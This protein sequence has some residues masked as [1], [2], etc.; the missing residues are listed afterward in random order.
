MWA[1]GHF[2][3]GKECSICG[4]FEADKPDFVTITTSTMPDDGGYVEVFPKQIVMSKEEIYNHL[5]YYFNN[6]E[7]F[8]RFADPYSHVTDNDG[9]KNLSSGYPWVATDDISEILDL[10]REEGFIDFKG[11]PRS[12]KGYTVLKLIP[13]SKYFEN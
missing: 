13:R 3:E 12:K 7:K 6:Q 4:H 1:P 8:S 9:G 11:Y 2:T 10:I 5:K